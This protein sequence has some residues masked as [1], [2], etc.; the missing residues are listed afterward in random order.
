MKF[1]YIGTLII[2]SLLFTSLQ[3]Q[4][5]RM[6]ATAGVN[7][8]NISGSELGTGQKFDN[9]DPRTSFHLGIV[10]E[11]FLGGKFYLGPEILYSSQGGKQDEKELVLNYIQIPIMARYYF[12]DGL[13]VEIGPQLGYLLSSSGELNDERISRDNFM[14]SDFSFAFGL[15]YKM[16][17]GFFLRGRYFLG[18]NV[19]ES[20]ESIITGDQ[21]IDYE[22]FNKV[23]QVSMGYMF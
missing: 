6:G 7:F 11:L 13:N 2:F 20:R 22:Y 15:G 4:K 18:T 21:V 1:K 12:T 3:A 17:N 10:S 5:F 14:K 19:A 23:A 8:A 9:L 16:N